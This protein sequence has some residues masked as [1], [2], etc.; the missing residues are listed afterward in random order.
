MVILDWTIL[1]LTLFVNGA[2]LWA[3]IDQLIAA[4]DDPASLV[5]GPFTCA[6]NS[7]W[8]QLGIEA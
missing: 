3:S 8:R 1:L 6:D 5:H 4:F 7:V 2:E